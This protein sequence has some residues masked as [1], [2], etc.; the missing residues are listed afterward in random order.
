MRSR[1]AP[2]DARLFTAIPDDVVPERSMAHPILNGAAELTGALRVITSRRIPDDR[3]PDAC[4]EVLRAMIA[5]T[6]AAAIVRRPGG[7]ATTGSG[8]QRLRD[9]ELSGCLAHGSLPPDGVWIGE[10]REFGRTPSVDRA[11]DTVALTVPGSMGCSLS[12]ALLFDERL[13]RDACDNARM[14]LEIVQPVVSSEAASRLRTTTR[15]SGGWLALDDGEALTLRELYNL[16]KRELDVTGLLLRGHSNREIAGRLNISAHTARHHT[17][18]VLE[19]LGI[20]SRA[21]IRRAL[22]LPPR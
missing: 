7:I 14:L 18:K 16:T 9:A 1:A 11:P 20:R 3:W 15:Y 21:A 13:T 12:V 17:E 19:K 10:A 2:S 4:A 5:A 8:A 6:S 22:H